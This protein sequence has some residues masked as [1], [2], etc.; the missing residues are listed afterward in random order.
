MP[1]HLINDYI[2]GAIG[3]SAGLLVGHPFDTT[4]VK[5]QTQHG[6]QLKGTVAMASNIFKQ[7]LTAG[8]FRGLSWPLMSYGVV[9]SVLFGVYGNTLKFLDKDKDTK[10]S[11]YLNIYLAGCV[12]GAAQLIPVIPTDYVK[13]VLQ[14]QIVPDT[15]GTKVHTPGKDP[16]FKG[17]IQCAKHVYRTKGLSGLYKGGGAMF[18]REVP[19]Y[20]LFLLVYESFSEGLK[21]KGWTDS[22][23]FIADF[24]AGGCAGSITWFS[25][26]PI[27]VVK[28]RYQADLL[29][30]YNGPLDCAVKSYKAEGLR[31]FYRGCAVTCVRAFPVN[32]VTFVV[33]SQILQYLDSR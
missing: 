4:K 12:G 30:Q 15:H 3:G 23:G 31:V 24:I 5:L 16:Y 2:A 25:I 29:G 14:S 22:K 33:Y 11:S 32:A 17:P 28:S 9:N 7:G 8:F 21:S 27:D 6:S 10:K 20:G 18:W 19:S 13:V 26:M 1:S